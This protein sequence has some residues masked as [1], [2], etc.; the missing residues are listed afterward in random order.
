[1]KTIYVKFWISAKGI[2]GLFYGQKTRFLGFLI[3][4]LKLLRSC[5]GIFRTFEGKLLVVFYCSGFKFIVTQ[6]IF[7]GLNI[8]P[9]LRLTKDKLLLCDVGGGVVVWGVF[10][11][12]TIC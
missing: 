7:I 11:F 5:P 4:I 10:T 6:Q 9:P 2:F 1:M 8:L 3:I 12:P